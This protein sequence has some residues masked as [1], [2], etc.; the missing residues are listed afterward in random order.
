MAH[1]LDHSEVIFIS[2]LNLGR[3]IDGPGWG[4]IGS[5]AS[6]FGSRMLPEICLMHDNEQ[7]KAPCS[8]SGC[9]ESHTTI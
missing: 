1:L 7:F 2:N 4:H 9:T 3:I 6:C 5:G 8:A